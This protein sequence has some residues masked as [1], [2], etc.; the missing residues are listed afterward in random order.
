MPKK[1]KYQD[2]SLEGMRPLSE[3]ILNA[4]MEHL[5]EEA[6]FCTPEESY[7]CIVW[8]EKKQKDRKERSQTLTEWQTRQKLEEESTGNS[9]LAPAE[10][11]ISCASTNLLKHYF[12]VTNGTKTP[13]VYL[14]NIIKIQLLYLRVKLIKLHSY[15]LLLYFF[16]DKVLWWR[17]RSNRVT[18]CSSLQIE[19]TK[20][21]AH[22]IC[23]PRED[24]FLVINV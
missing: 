16:S 20:W 9:Y 11:T 3:L 4:A 7:E 12:N 18:F 8:E 2:K 22:V 10:E 6:L 13:R 19:I 21:A 5:S 15:I 17:R 1:L 14:I 23:G 24:T